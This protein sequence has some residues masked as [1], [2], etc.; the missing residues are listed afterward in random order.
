[1]PHYRYHCLKE[2]ARPSLA[3]PFKAPACGANLRTGGGEYTCQQIDQ[4]TEQTYFAITGVTV[5][6]C[7]SVALAI[8]LYGY[9]IQTNI[10]ADLRG[11]CMSLEAAGLKGPYRPCAEVRGPREF[12]V[13]NRG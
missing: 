5:L 6:F 11:S 12:F 8:G 3:R 1:M 10:H 9:F 2:K 7:V 4:P 13:T